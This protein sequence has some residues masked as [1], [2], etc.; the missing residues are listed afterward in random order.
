ATVPP[1][2]RRRL[3][4]RVP[5]RIGGPRDARPD[6]RR[7]LAP[8]HQPVPARRARAPPL[9]R[10]QRAVPDRPPLARL[11]PVPRVLPWGQRRGAGGEPPDGLD[12]PR[13]GAY[14]AARG[15]GNLMILL[16]VAEE[17]Q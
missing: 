7:P 12:R 2:L 3:P 14:T 10:R 15:E 9:Q 5:H 17:V 11:H 4:D 8:P 6:R 1:L 16:P 13:G